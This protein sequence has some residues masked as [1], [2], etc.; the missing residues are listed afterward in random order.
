M[1][2]YTKFEELVNLELKFAENNMI[3]A[4]KAENLEK[5]GFLGLV[6]KLGHYETQIYFAQKIA[7]LKEVANWIVEKPSMDYQEIKYYK[8]KFLDLAMNT[9]VSSSQFENA[10]RNIQRKAAK[11]MYNLFKQIA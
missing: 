1:I 6:S 11:E 10:F 9:E 8:E 3:D 4:L 5:I 2:T 7:Y